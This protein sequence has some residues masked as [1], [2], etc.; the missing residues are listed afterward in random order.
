VRAVR[1]Q[2]A[3]LGIAAA[4]ALSGTA[5]ALPCGVAEPTRVTGA[6]CTVAEA[7]PRVAEYRQ[8]AASERAPLAEQPEVLLDAAETDI[9]ED[10]QVFAGAGIK[11]TNLQATMTSNQYVARRLPLAASRPIEDLITISPDYLTVKT[12]DPVPKRRPVGVGLV[13]VPKPP[14][15][16]TDK[17]SEV[18]GLQPKRP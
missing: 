8:P 13:T 10:S 17:E 3:A 4:A 15:K 11:I 14:P 6:G 2:S 12:L 5:S 1:A 7:S 9:T 18:P 16:E